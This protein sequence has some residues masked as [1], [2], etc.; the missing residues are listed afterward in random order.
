M[1]ATHFQYFDTEMDRMDRGDPPPVYW[2]HFHWGYYADPHDTDDSPELYAASAEQLTENLVTL[3]GIG[4]NRI[5]LDV[6]CGFGG[7]LDHVRARNRGCRLIGVNVDF[8][9]LQRGRQLVA[10]HPRSRHDDPIAFVTA[11]GC[12]LPLADNSVD[13]VLAVECIFHFPSRRAFFREAARVLKPGGTLALSDFLLAAGQTAAVAANMVDAGFGDWY[14]Y[15]AKPLTAAGYQRLARGT[16]FETI[17]DED[18]TLR[19][20]PTYPAVRRIYDE[21]GEPEGV[22]DINGLEMMAAKGGWE[23]HLLAYRQQ[24]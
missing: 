10:T 3:A 17:A 23:Y 24:D 8:R 4:D 16:G 9:Q 19:T 5:V 15:C 22:R 14:G 18:I 7:T 21:A 20:M 13:H 1:P 12:R 6:G 2:R 11:D